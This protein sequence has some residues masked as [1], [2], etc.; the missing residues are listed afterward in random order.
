MA[1]GLIRVCG[2]PYRRV[3]AHG[4]G[5]YPLGVAWVQKGE[6]KRVQQG[7]QYPVKEPTGL[8]LFYQDSH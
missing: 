7:Q 4:R 5:D 1:L 2:G 3:G 6:K 8:M